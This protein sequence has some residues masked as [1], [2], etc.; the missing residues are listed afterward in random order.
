MKKAHK[1]SKKTEKRRHI[2]DI[3]HYLYKYGADDLPLDPAKPFISQKIRKFL[4][5]FHT[6]IVRPHNFPLS[7][8]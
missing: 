1:S 3:P 7:F 2:D 8:N 6:Q 5:H 4:K